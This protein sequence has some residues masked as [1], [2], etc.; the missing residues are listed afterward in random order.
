MMRTKVVVVAT[1]LAEVER[2]AWFERLEK[3]TERRRIGLCITRK[4]GWPVWNKWIVR[5]YPVSHSRSGSNKKD[6]W[7]YWETTTTTTRAMEHPGKVSMMPG[8]PVWTLARGCE[9]CHC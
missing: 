4:R 8:Q 5:H 7:E 1:T 2:N 3:W 9:R 6:L